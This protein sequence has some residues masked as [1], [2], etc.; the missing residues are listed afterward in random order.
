MVQTALHQTHTENG[1]TQQSDTASS[2][3]WRPRVAIGWNGV[4]R[5]LDKPTLEPITSSTRDC[6]KP[7]RISYSIT[8]QRCKSTLQYLCI[9]ILCIYIIMYIIYIRCNDSI[10]LFIPASFRASDNAI[11]LFDLLL[12]FNSALQNLRRYAAMYCR[13]AISVMW[14]TDFFSV[15]PYLRRKT[16]K[17]GPSG[18]HGL[19]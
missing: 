3:G 13:D 2:H 9:Y 14:A 16:S 8:W 11:P 4:P 1:I 15:I 7:T 6:S 17:C 19:V 12:T 10:G 5:F 18:G